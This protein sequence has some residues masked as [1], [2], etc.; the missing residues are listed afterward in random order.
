MNKNTIDGNKI[1]Q[2]LQRMKDI[3]MLIISFID[4]EDK[5]FFK[6]FFE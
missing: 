1:N 5:V 3:E 6:E 4:D 2:F